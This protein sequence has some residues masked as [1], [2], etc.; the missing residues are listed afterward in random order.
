[1][2]TLDTMH[3]LLHDDKHRTLRQRA[4]MLVIV[5]VLTGSWLGVGYVWRG[6][7]EH[8]RVE[9]IQADYITKLDAL[10]EKQAKELEA[11]RERHGRALDTLRLTCTK[12]EIEK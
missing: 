3:G 6:K 10:R 7:S 5:T 11:L 1:M 4:E 12:K 2:S 8:E 9:R